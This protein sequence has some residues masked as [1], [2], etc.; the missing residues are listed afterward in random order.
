LTGWVYFRIMKPYLFLVFGLSAVLFTSSCRT[1]FEGTELL[2]TAPESHTIV[3]TIIRPG[4]DRLESEVLIQWWGDDPDGF[5]IGYEFTFDDLQAPIVNWQFTEKQDS[6]FVLAP[7]PGADTLDFVFSVRSID[8]LYLAD[9]TPATLSYPVKNSPPSVQFLPGLNNP[10]ISFPALKFFWEGS[11]PDGTANLSGYEL[12]WND[13][14]AESLILDAEVSNVLFEA[15]D[16]TATALTCR[17]FVNS[18][19]TAEAATLEGLTAN[20][21]NR[22]YIRAIDQSDSRSA[23]VASDSIWIKPVHSNFLLVNAYT[24]ISNPLSFYT[25]QLNAIGFTNFD[26]LHIFEEMDGV[27]TQQSADNLTQERVLDMFDLIIWFSNSAESSLSLAQKTTGDFF[28]DGGKLLMSIYVSSSFDPLSNFLEF[29]PIASLVSPEDTTLILDLGAQLNPAN[30]DYPVLEGTAIIGVVKPVNLQLGANIVYEA[31][32]TA[33][34]NTTLTFSPWEGNSIV[35]ASK[36]VGGSVNFVLS[37]LELQKLNGLLN[38]PDL[39]QK[40]IIDEFN[41]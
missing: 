20:S 1:G 7:P 16:P 27:Y 10:V 39:F 24:T 19:E 3:D 14:L 41:F 38:M 31:E 17:L 8:N 13:T 4:D 25:E 23:W 15:V 22:L 33:K 40:I 18:A 29:T 21:W 28:A 36:S 26:T 12:A 37:T 35:I 11:D 9:P 32:L 34:D 5:I 6:I 2:N 30:P